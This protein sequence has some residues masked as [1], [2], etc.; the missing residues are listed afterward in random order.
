MLE[1]LQ[2]WDREIFIYLNGLGSKKYDQF[3]IAVT[4]I[5]T[6]IPLFL[7]FLLLFILKLPKKRA[8]FNIVSVTAVALFI[9]LLTH[10]VKTWVKRPRPCHDE[11]MNSFVRIL[12]T[13]VDY[14][15]FSGHA[16]SSF[17]ITT[18]VVLLLQHK[19]KWVWM[20][21]LWPLLFAYS[22]I[23]VGAH[24][25]TDILAGALIGT[26]VGILCYKIQGKLIKPWTR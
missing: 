6:W 3:W 2:T 9:A 11:S 24:F 22:R 4:E 7:L 20:F 23:Y 1:H 21:F 16:S 5:S 10:L 15:F 18:L 17:A 25:P 13:P 12:K 19:I 8:F 14:S 26:G